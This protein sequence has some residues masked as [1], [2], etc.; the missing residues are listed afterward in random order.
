MAGDARS[1]LK[2]SKKAFA[3]CTCLRLNGWGCPFGIE[4]LMR[5]QTRGKF[6]LSKWLGMP[7]RD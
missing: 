3:D 4:T 2:P 1:G 7:V 5:I 6:S